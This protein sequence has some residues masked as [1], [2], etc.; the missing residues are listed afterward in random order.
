MRASK[1]GINI[2]KKAKQLGV[3]RQ[4]ITAWARQGV[5]DFSPEAISEMRSQ[6]NR[7]IMLDAQK[8]AAEWGVKV[9]TAYGHLKKGT[10]PKPKLPRSGP[11]YWYSKSGQAAIYMAEINRENK[12]FPDWG[13][14]WAKEKI[15]R[16]QSKSA[17]KQWKHVS[18]EKRDEINAKIRASRATDE[19]REKRREY[20]RKKVEADPSIK[21]QGALRTRL[22]KFIRGNNKSGI[23][24]LLGCSWLQFRR[25]LESQF[26]RGITWENYGTHWHVD[27][28]IPCKAFDHGNPAQVRQCWHFTNLRPLEA[29]ANMAKG[30][31]IEAP[32]LSLLLTA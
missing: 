9:A 25:H 8:K 18:R 13:V 28:I 24:N 6:Q 27:H 11:D 29:S 2:S 23:R 3:S 4:T 15:R 17:K 12:S 32:Q 7:G 22:R 26:T 31:K 30:A 19:Y 20:K 21:I 1:Y 14:I 10:K 5:R 16:D